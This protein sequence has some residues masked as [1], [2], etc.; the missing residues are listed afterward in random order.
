MSTFRSVDVRS[1]DDDRVL[2]V[3]GL[4]TRCE[5]TTSSILKQIVRNVFKTQKINNNKRINLLHLEI[6]A[7]LV[8]IG[9]LNC[10]FFAV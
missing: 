3:R 1:F 6:F 8:Q 4:K 9:R 10:S 5:R 2:W 7:H